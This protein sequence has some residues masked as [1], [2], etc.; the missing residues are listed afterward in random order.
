MPIP[1][2][3]QPERIDIDGTLRLRKFDNDYAQALA[4]YQDPE[5]VRLVDGKADPYTPQRLQR[6]YDYLAA[7]GEL[8]WIECRAKD[9]IFR[10][11]GDVTFWQEDMPI[12]IGD[13]AFRGRGIGRRVI[14]ALCRRARELNYNN[15]YVNEIYDFNLPSIRCFT[16]AGF[17][18]C[19]VTERGKRY[20][21]QTGEDE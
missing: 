13:P 10:P 6:M 19:G 11:I 18:P 5:T 9:G 4:W 3:T 2:I 16:A 20:V 12:V 1:G 8:W 21:R 17:Q 15:I 14:K 7:R